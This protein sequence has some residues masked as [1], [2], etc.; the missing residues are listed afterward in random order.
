VVGARDGQRDGLVGQRRVDLGPLGVGV[1]DQGAIN[2]NLGSNGL[3]DLD[4]GQGEVRTTGSRGEHDAII[5]ELDFADVGHASGGASF[6]LAV[7]DLARGIG[8]VDGVVSDAF[9]ELLEAATGAARADD[10]GL[11]LGESSAE[12]FSHDRGEGQ[13][14]RRTGDL[15]GVARLGESGGAEGDERNDGS[16]GEECRL[17]GEFP[18]GIQFK[19]GWPIRQFIPRCRPLTRGTIWGPRDSFIAVA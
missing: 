9:A 8:D 13:D 19:P 10:R 2:R 5:A 15:D 18:F 1:V 12:F 7:L 17:H 14:G 4:R 6:E 3:V 16:T 11:E